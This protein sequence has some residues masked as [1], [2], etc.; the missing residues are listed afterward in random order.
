M[1]WLLCIVLLWTCGCMYLFFFLLR[2]TPLAYGG[3]QARSQI[4]AA[5][6]GL[7]HSHSNVGYEL[8]LWPITQLEATPDP[9]THWVRPGTEP[10]SSWILAGFLMHL[11]TIGTLHVCFLWKFCPDMCPG[12]GLVGHIV[13][14]YLVLSCLH[15]IF[16]SG[17]ISLHSHQHC[18]RG[19]LFS[20]PSPAFVIF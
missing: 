8:C 6:A 1:S 15:M 19:S 11:A 17:C 3:S 7:N 12:V 5:A 9:L 18:R 20:A 10:E 16:H 14:L 4:G 2:A 13:V